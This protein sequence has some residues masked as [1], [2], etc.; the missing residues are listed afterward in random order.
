MRVNMDKQCK[1]S[2]QAVRERLSFWILQT[3]HAACRVEELCYRESDQDKHMWKD[4]WVKYV[5]RVEFLLAIYLF[6]N[7]SIRDFGIILLENVFVFYFCPTVTSNS[8]GWCESYIAKRLDIFAALPKIIN[9]SAIH[10]FAFDYWK[11]II[12]NIN[13]ATLTPR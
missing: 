12:S 4:W 10:Y 11:E 9:L 2:A 6:L 5:I 7:L 3:A 13:W 1:A 8:T